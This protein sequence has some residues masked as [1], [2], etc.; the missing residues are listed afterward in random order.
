MRLPVQAVREA[1]AS[2][3]TPASKHTQPRPQ[4]GPLDFAH[5]AAAASHLV[6]RLIPAE[7][8]RERPRDGAHSAGA[9]AGGPGCPPI[10]T[11]A[12]VQPGNS[13]FSAVAA[14]AAAAPLRSS[15]SRP[16]SAPRERPT[17]PAPAPAAAKVAFGRS[18]PP[19]P[20]PRKTAP[21]VPAAA[22]DIR[23]SSASV[24]APRL[25]PLYFCNNLSRYAA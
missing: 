19:P 23:V 3:K 24:R 8:V 16:Q 18:A 9:L 5:V 6:A 15:Q 12:V 22:R 11:P 25:P 14:A 20:P 13:K 4:S 7:V 17:T 1:A 2:F 21:T 10:G